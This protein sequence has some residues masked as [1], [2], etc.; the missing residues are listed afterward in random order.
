MD[1]ESCLR[2][3]KAKYFP[4]AGRKT[5]ACGS[6]VAAVLT[7]VL[8]PIQVPESSDLHHYSRAGFFSAPY[9]YSQVAPSR[10]QRAI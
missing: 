3:I 2:E 9:I 6:R 5:Q 4:Q 10:S 1:I 8:K 7:G